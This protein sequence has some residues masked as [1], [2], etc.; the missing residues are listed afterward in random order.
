[1]TCKHCG[2]PIEGRIHPGTNL[3]RCKPTSDR[4][5]GYN[6]EP[7]GT[8]CVYPCLGAGWQSAFEA[9]P[10]PQPEPHGIGLDGRCDECDPQP[11]PTE[12]GTTGRATVQEPDRLRI[13]N[14]WLVREVSE[15]TCGAGDSMHGHEPGCGLIPE[16]H[17]AALPG[18]PTPATPSPQP[19]PTGLVERVERATTDPGTPAGLTSAA[20]RAALAVA[21]W[22]DEQPYYQQHAFAT[23]IRREVEGSG[24]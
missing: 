1:M 18:W 4:P 16:L 11:E 5:Y 23:L 14:G 21:D 7:E 8:D 19:E 6:A 10:S 13:E 3:M 2:E 12:P 9:T 20:H 24:A 22:L 15:H 17:L